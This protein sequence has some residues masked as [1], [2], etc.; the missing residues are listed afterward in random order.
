MSSKLSFHSIALFDAKTEIDKALKTWALKPVRFSYI[1]TSP[2]FQFGSNVIPY[3][4]NF[5]ESKIKRFMIQ[6]EF[7]ILARRTFSDLN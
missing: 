1:P 6:I 5:S 2:P 4:K 7:Q 3:K